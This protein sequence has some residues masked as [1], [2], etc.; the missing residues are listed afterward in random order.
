MPIDSADPIEYRPVDDVQP[1]PDNPKAHDL[2]TLSASIRRFGFAEP[3]V[4]DQRTGL[5]L[6]GHG[7]IEALR[8]L[9][10]SDEEPPDGIRIDGDGR[11]LVPVYAGWQST[12]DNE[13]RAALVA[14]NR[15]GER[16]GWH[17]NSLLD[18]LDRLAELDDGLDGVGWA[19]DE[20]EVLRRRMEA[21]GATPVDPWAEWD[22]AGMPDYDQED[23]QSAA[24]VT[25]HF[26]TEAD[27][28]KF[29]ELIDCP[30]RKSMWW[31]HDDGH[32][33]CTVGEE[34]VADA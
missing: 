11:W 1:H 13:A 21:L 6:S 28:D 16:G 3:I 4:I 26:P 9:R 30:R 23:K 25:I 33:G 22:N 17:E 7:R 2:D 15:S 10:R 29:F 27:A 8:Q 32:Q 34:W 14:L 24:S 20:I 19:D 5:N 31:P 12:T 18:L